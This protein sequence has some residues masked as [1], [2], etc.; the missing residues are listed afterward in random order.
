[1]KTFLSS[2][3]V[4]IARV[5]I[6]TAG[7][8]PRLLCFDTV[9]SAQLEP[10]ISKGE[11]TELRVKNTIIAQNYLEDIIKGYNITLKDAALS[12]ELLTLIDGGTPAEA[13][14]AAFSGYSAP[15]AG[16]VTERTRF[17]M[18]IYSEEKDYSGETVAVY[19]FT[20]PGCFGTPCSMSF[21]NGVFAA[22]EYTVRSRSSSGYSMRIQCLDR[23]PV[24]C[25]NSNQ[26]PQTPVEGDC[27]I[28]ATALSVGE[29]ALAVGE[30]AYYT[31]SE[32][33]KIS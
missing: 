1:M 18:S 14:E 8:S 25:T 23:L 9:S 7:D 5:E 19:R 29:N 31:G 33:V 27:V 2:A 22:P 30:L 13:G 21:E 24:I 20:Y 17:T 6:L 11:E 15:A 26:A 10:F 16:T 12:K 3:I 32:W 4:N 28:A